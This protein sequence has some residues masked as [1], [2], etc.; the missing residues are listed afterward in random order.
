MKRILLLLVAICCFAAVNAQCPNG[1]V[2]IIVTITPDDYPNET[3]WTLTYAQSGAVIAQGAAIGDTVCVPNNSCIKFTINDSYGDGI[4]C[5]Y[6]QGSYSVT[7]GGQLVAQ[8]GSFSN[9]ESTYFN[10]PP[11]YACSNAIDVAL[12]TYNAPVTNMWYTF[13]PD[14]IGTYAITTCG[15]NTCNTKIW[16]YDNCVGLTYDD[17][18]IGTVFYDDNNGGCGLQ[19]VVT[20]YMDSAT[21]YYIR[22]GDVGASCAANG[23]NWEIEYL[24]PVVGC[25]DPNSCNY[26]P[27]ATV[28]GPCYAYGSV[29]CPQ[30]P[31]LMVVQDAIVNSMDVDQITVDDCYVQEGCVT[32]FGLRDI[33]RFTTHIKN[34]GED[35]YFIG[36][37]QAGTQ[38]VF[39][40]CHGHWHYVGYAQYILINQQGTEIPVGFKNGFCVL[41][42]ECSD[43]GTAQY[44]CGNMGITAG[45][46]DI[47]GSGLACQWID[48][49][50]VDTGQYMLLVR[51]NWDQSPDALGRQESDYTNNQA[52]VCIRLTRD[53]NG[54][55]SFIIDND[56]PTFVDC[57]GVEYGN[58]ETDCNGTCNGSAI[59]GDLDADGERESED[60]QLYVAEILD[61]TA[62]ALPCTDL[63]GNG[64]IT[65][66]D[67]AL[68]NKCALLGNPDNNNECSFPQNFINPDD[69]VS[70]SMID[71]NV[72]LNY[73]EIAMK[74]P[75]HKVNA[76]Q[77]TMHGIKILG[78]QNMVDPLLYPINPEYTPGGTEVIGISYQGYVTEKYITPT[79][80]CRIYF[81]EITDTV[82]CI[83]KI[84]DV[85]NELYQRTNTVIGGNCYQVPLTGV[86]EDLFSVGVKVY[87][88]PSD[89]IFNLQLTTAKTMD[90]KIVVNDMVGK[91]VRSVAG[92][93]RGQQIIPIDLAGMPAGVYSVTVTSG[94]VQNTQ[95]LV[96]M[97]N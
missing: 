69:T 17:S 42:L 19:A 71:V 60:A 86:N 82:I 10:C 92:N 77:F 76:Y 16:V 91:Q 5:G 97:G 54:I 29:Q 40:P 59:K 1:Q 70:L 33:I 74:N 96:F 26:N 41:D 75:A 61:G 78:V 81:S 51:V 11:G 2:K 31:D 12:G 20:A 79:P 23:I 68:D 53:G 84:T 66:Y 8:G 46:G 85:V 28:A 89:G 45:C 43:G 25:M 56:C 63:S 93:G 73:V 90:Y 6:G 87:P 48:I 32:G 9:T 21:T 39:D 88:N 22:I 7:L 72:D 94:K 37:P 36:Q 14:S 55:P 24:G 18:N 3:S 57:M 49:T 4:C 34:I 27:L 52:Q 62:N 80:L 38:F 47:Y 67:A 83:E 15:T 64:T 35:D 13:K 50:D 95:R 44:G 65:V 58:A 30:A